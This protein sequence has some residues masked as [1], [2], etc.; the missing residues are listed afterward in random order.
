MFGITKS[1]KAV[2]IIKEGGTAE[3]S[4]AQIIDL[5]VNML[6]AMKKL[7]K[8]EYRAVLGV[9][10]YYR[11]L[12]TK[13]TMDFERYCE[14]CMEIISDLDEAAP[15]EI[16]CGDVDVERSILQEIRREKEKA[17]QEEEANEIEGAEKEEGIEEETDEID[18]AE[19]EEGIED[20]N[21]SH[22]K[23]ESS[24]IAEQDKDDTE[25]YYFETMEEFII[26]SQK[27]E[28]SNSV[29][30]LSGDDYID[31]LKEGYD[32]IEM[33]D[34]EGA[35]N[36]LQEALKLNPIGIS[37]R[38]ELCEAYL[39]LQK[40]SSAENTLLEMRE[41]FTS[42]EHIAKF[43]RRLGFIQTDNYK[44]YAA[45]AACYAYSLK[46]EKHPSVM[47]ELAYIVNL[48]GKKVLKKDSV[49]ILK[50]NGIP[51]IEAEGLCEE[52]QSVK[53]AVEGTRPSAPLHQF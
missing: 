20:D 17:R 18:G 26:Y 46:F 31:K 42:P 1:L 13:E 39:R 51:V 12:K 7:P 52:E 5:I 44:N 19:K 45:A 38:F 33:N 4:R 8:E 24:A 43:Y 40:Y 23:D 49:A 48:G 10:D 14:I 27:H 22:E 50:K 30:W 2:R 34:P 29:I 3:L 25:K 16:Y 28:G 9:Y 35:V 15:Y 21:H 6:D 11:K 53:E 41:L 36:A 32:L 47:Q 37:A